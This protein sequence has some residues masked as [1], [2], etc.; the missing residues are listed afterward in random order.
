LAD[1]L[2]GGIDGDQLASVLSSPGNP[3]ALLAAGAAELT[4]HAAENMIAQ[5][6][7]HEFVARVLRTDGLPVEHLALP[8]GGAVRP[9]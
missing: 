7:P 8:E 9:R 1:K 6:V 4:Q 3:W 5:G 2:G